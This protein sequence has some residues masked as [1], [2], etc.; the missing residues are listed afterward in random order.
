LCVSAS[1][2]QSE[3]NFSSVGCTVTDMHSR[4]STDNV[5]AVELVCLGML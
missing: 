5:E 3:R 2:A 4:L 1:S